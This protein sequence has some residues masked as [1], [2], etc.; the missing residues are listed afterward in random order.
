MVHDI[1][2][3]LPLFIPS[4]HKH[5]ACTVPNNLPLKLREIRKL[6]HISHI[7]SNMADI[8]RFW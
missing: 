4:V 5:L 7:G 1:G 2:S 6:V 8:G 3:I